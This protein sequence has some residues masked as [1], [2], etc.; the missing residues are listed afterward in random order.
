MRYFSQ[1]SGSFPDTSAMRFSHLFLIILYWSTCFISKADQFERFTENGKVGLRNTTT[2]IVVIP[3][4]YEELGWSDKNFSV[5]K[6]VTGALQNE[7]WALVDIE[8]HRITEQLFSTLLPSAEGNFIASKRQINS[9]LTTYG[10]IDSKGKTIILFEYSSISSYPSG[11]IVSK[12]K[13]GRYESGFMNEK[14]SIQIPVE[15]KQV[16]YLNNGHLAVSDFNEQFA[17]YETSGKA[18]TGF[19]YEYIIPHGNHYYI[20][21]QY[22]H[23]GLLK[24]NMEM[25]IP[26]LYKSLEFGTQQV[27]AIPYREWDYFEND[28]YKNTLYF[29]KVEI[30]GENKFATEAE[31]KTGLIDSENHYDLFLPEERLVNGN[32][33]ILITE[34]KN[35]GRYHVYNQEGKRLFRDSFDEISLFDQVIFG[36]INQ[37]DGHSWAVYNFEGKKLNLFNYQEFRKRSE[38]FFEAK[39]NGKIGLIGINGKE[40]SPF[41]YD[42]LGDYRNGRAIAWYNGSYGVI[43]DQGIWIMTPYYDSLALLDDQIYFKQGSDYGLA[44][45]FGKVL[46]RSHTAFTPTDNAIILMDEDST[47]SLRSFSGELL[48]EHRYSSIKELD[49]DL[50]LLTREKQKFLFR[51]SNAFDAKLDPLIDSLGQYLNGYVPVKKDGQW[52]FLNRSGGLAIA[53]RYEA[54]GTF[55]EGL[56]SVKLIGKWGY[57]NENEELVIQ[58]NYEETEPFQSGLAIVKNAG[59]YGIINQKSEAVVSLD[60]EQIERLGNL[61]LLHTSGQIGLADSSGRIIKNPSYESIFPLDE[62]FFLVKRNGKYG[63][64]NKSGHD[65]L[66]TNYEE[67]RQRGNL[68]L[69]SKEGQS[70]IFKLK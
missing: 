67:I 17:I 69:G 55:S 5:V 48:L 40:S 49:K 9:I 29:D 37:A 43:N 36:K 58:P 28:S 46:Y 2:D 44:D 25:I 27:M 53:N 7:K 59:K 52:G 65:I 15:F 12:K 11:L 8:G 63:V 13:G 54:V 51:P 38:Q 47:F 21:G 70:R 39:R 45:W 4:K 6:G 41:L 66:P 62:D 3:A 30:I 18:L 20:I 32:E 68:F 35:S 16:N 64:I 60:Y 24:D 23:K 61:F 26:P 57:V 10:L 14:G 42:E 33:N 50:L 56:F 19:Q 22:N 1:F 34:D 31:G